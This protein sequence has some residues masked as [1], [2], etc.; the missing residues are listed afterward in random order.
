MKAV[1]LATYLAADT[2]EQVK[3]AMPK[4]LEYMSTAF[5]VKQKQ[6]NYFIK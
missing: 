2:T 6:Q 4:P 1:C 5:S 3:S